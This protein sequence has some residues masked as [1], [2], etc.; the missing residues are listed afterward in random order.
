MIIRGTTPYHSFII[1]LTK[2]E[3]DTIYVT[4]WQNGEVV[5]E[6]T[7]ED[8]TIMNLLDLLSEDVEIEDLTEEEKTSCQI[9]LHLTQEDTLKFNFYPAARKNIAVIQIRVKTLD[10]EAYGSDPIRERIMGVLKEG[11]I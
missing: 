4:Y 8:M 3:I 7:K 6:K 11:E 5:L 10:G 2:E 1:P 9:E